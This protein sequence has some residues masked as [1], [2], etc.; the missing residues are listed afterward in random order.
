MIALVFLRICND[1]KNGMIESRK[2]LLITVVREVGYY[3][4]AVVLLFYVYGKQ[5]WSCREVR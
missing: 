2:V 3:V 4:I 1:I 5:L